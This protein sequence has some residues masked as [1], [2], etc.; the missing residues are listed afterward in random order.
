MFL[1]A[2][3]NLFYRLAEWI[4][5]VFIAIFPFI[6]YP[7]WLFSG[8]ATRSINLIIFIELLLIIFAVLLF[9]KNI[10]L[11]ILKSPITLALGLFLM[12]LFIT[13][14]NGVDF[15]TSFWSKVTRMTGLFYFLHLG[16]FYLFCVSFFKEERVFRNFLNTF[17]ISTGLFSLT[18]FTS[19]GNS[20]IGNS[21]FAAMYIY[22]AFM[23]S[24]YWVISH[25]DGLKRWWHNL[26]PL[27]FVINP[28]IINKDLWLGR[29]NIFTNPQDI[30][31]NAQATSYTILI[32][33]FFLFG[34]WLVMRIKNLKTQRIV[35]LGG[36]G[37]GI[38]V[39][40]FIFYFLLL[41]G[42]YIQ[43]RFFDKSSPAR[44]IVWELSR[45]AIADKPVLGW[46]T[47]NFD[48]AFE[49]NY[50]NH[51]LENKNGSEMWFDRAHN[52]FLDQ[53]AETGMVGLISYLLIYLV[54]IV[55]LVYVFLS[56]L[57]KKDRYLSAI[58]VVYFVGHILELQT[59]FDTTI[60]YVPLVIMMAISTILFHR[61]YTNS[62]NKEL[63]WPVSENFG[64][65]LGVIF[66]IFS[67]Y[68]FII[69]TW[70]IIK[71]EIANG[72]VQKA[73]SSEKRLPLYPILFGSSMDKATFLWRTSS[74]FQ[75]GVA[76]NLA[77]LQDTKRVEGLKKELDLFVNE[78]NKYIEVNP[79]DFRSHLG[80]ANIY[81]YQRLF[82]V[83]H[84]KEA[85]IVLDKAIILSPKM[86]QPYWMKSVAYLYMRK[87]DL[88]REW[89][90]KAY[91]LN[92]SVERS[93]VVIDYINSSIKTFP[94]IDLY[95]FW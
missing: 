34:I 26:I 59:A 18:S 95:N 22:V 21:T 31:G 50:D 62:R 27:I 52:I 77:I 7:G 35:V 72:D 56:T 73:G 3:N 88:A 14:L 61:T 20:M 85:Q 33:I 40:S 44:Q 45:Q 8:T 4:F 30:V 41:P 75:R 25:K 66:I 63:V 24:I 29:V 64:Y 19:W 80:L 36:A 9:K 23:L 94:E 93:Q 84:L 92:P 17:L 13:G 83:D 69:G 37:F 58:L 81:I 91:D 82:E 28:Y 42:G 67:L 12:V 70:P 49:L 68:F 48:R 39:A 11:S 54:L 46:G 38:V 47:D 74:D 43:Q 71:A 15:S 86:E 6:V 65:V 89:A 78:Y 2:K 60:S 51:L 79:N 32:S 5:Y 10:T 1:G 76:Q 87:F 90:K 16:L 53:L 57:E 55:C